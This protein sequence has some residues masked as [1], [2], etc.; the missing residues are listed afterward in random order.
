MKRSL[1]ILFLLGLAL[2]AGWN[3]NLSHPKAGPP[4][5]SDTTAATVVYTCPMHPSVISDRPGACP[6]CG[7]ALVRK[8]GQ[9]AVSQRD[10]NAL[11]QVSLSPA[12][13]V[14]ANISTVKAQRTA[15]S[16]QFRL[17]GIVQVAQPRQATVTARFR[18][19]VEK[20]HVNYGGA[21]VAKGTP[22]FELYSPDLISA[23][24]EYL[25][26]FQRDT[27]GVLTRAARQRLMTHFG[28]TEA[29]VA[30]I[31][32]TGTTRTSMTFTAPIAG[33]V[34]RKNVQEG[35]Y[36]SEGTSLYEL[37]DLS[38]VWIIFD[39][40][41]QDIR[42][43]RAGQEVIIGS[44]ASPEL[45]L[46]GR[47]TFVDPVVD[48]ETRTVKVRTEF[49][50]PRGALRPEMFVDGIIECES[51]TALTVPVNALLETGSRSVVW[52]ETAVNAFE[53]RDVTVGTRNDRVVEILI[54]LSEGEMVAATGGYLLDS[55]SQF[56]AP[57]YQE[58][59]PTA[60][61]HDGMT[62]GSADVQVV[63][64]VVDGTY[65]PD[66][67]HVR[68][69]I[70]VRLQFDRRDSGACT[71][72]VVFKSLGIRRKLRT[73]AVTT[74]EFIPVKNGE[75]VFTCGMEMVEGKLVVK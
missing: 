58:K 42:S 13:R 40:S 14:A 75:I 48:P 16:R 74:I 45:N 67:I 68:N 22:L 49:A 3:C 39:V 56:Q 9:T 38:V 64:I 46:T 1:S 32:R 6:V 54:G 41:E 20:V 18:G 7:M 72:E 2:F 53:P 55:E 12:Q 59:K 17:P 60:H 31:V 33:T 8:S 44:R 4:G 43:I 73:G 57:A 37:A 65:S 25:L 69:G 70:P 26:A 30:E 36:V 29:Q 47:I 28:M 66:V 24:Q 50:N 10:L 27:Q 63:T 15:F 71:D 19:R 61:V 34:L 21:V 62:Q 35:Q 51:R 23:Q 52:I 11:R 5:A